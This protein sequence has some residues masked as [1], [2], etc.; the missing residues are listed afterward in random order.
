MST[1]V[2]LRTVCFTLLPLVAAAI[3]AHAA[4]QFDDVPI[5][6]THIHLYDTARPQGV[7][8]PPKSDP[9]LYRPIMPVDFNR[10]AQ[11]HGVTAAVVVEASDWMEDNRWVLKL[12]RENP[13]RLVGFVGSLEFGHDDFAKYLAELAQDDHFV[14]LRLSQRPRGNAFFNAEV[15]R[16]LRLLAKQGMTLDVLMFDF[17]LQDVGTIAERLPNLKIVMNHVANANIDGLAPDEK[18]TADIQ[19]VAKHSNVYCKISGL[20]QQAKR[21][22][23]PD[24]VEFYR[25]VL[26]VVTK[27]FG[28]DRIIYGSN[29]PVTMH[30]GEY[31]QYQRIV[32]EY[33]RPRGRAIVEKLLYKNAVEFYS[34]KHFVR[35]I[36]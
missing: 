34:L 30:G 18:W 36:E 21:R 32:L 6:D 4:G 1:Q 29:W 24:D 2:G 11:I 19:H 28:E 12:A 15:W 35:A 5:I 25:P 31:S 22:P 17:S 26:D 7:P 33:Y 14:G 10:I 16:D 23:A 13:K 27:A 8:W 9:V 3:S 20:F